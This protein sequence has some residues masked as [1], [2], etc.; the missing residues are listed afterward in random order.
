MVDRNPSREYGQYCSAVF[1]NGKHK[2]P[3]RIEVDASDVL[4]VRKRQG[5]ASVPNDIQCMARDSF[6]KKHILGQVED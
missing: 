2:V 6:G 4:P 1:V 5:I 3:L